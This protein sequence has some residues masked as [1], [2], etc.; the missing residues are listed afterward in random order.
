MDG[1]YGLSASAS[2]EASKTLY[3]PPDDQPLTTWPQLLCA[4]SRGFLACLP[5]L[6]DGLSRDQNKALKASRAEHLL[7]RRQVDSKFSISSLV[8]AFWFVG[9]GP[10]ALS[11]LLE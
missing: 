9:V 1:P 3:P 5:S 2:G 10:R 11:F 7:T 6:T 4:V 8:L